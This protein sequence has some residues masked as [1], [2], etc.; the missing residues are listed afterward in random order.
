M[1][2]CSGNVVG[3]GSGGSG[4]DGGQGGQGG[5]GGSWPTSS[6]IS[7]SMAA[8]YGVAMTASTGSGIA[9]QDLDGYFDVCCGGDDCDDANPNIHPGASETAGDGVDSNCDGSDDT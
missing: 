3:G 8:S 7:Y 5:R 1:I 6:A 4:G 2:A 9:D